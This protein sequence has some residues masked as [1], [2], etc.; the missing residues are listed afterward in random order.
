MIDVLMLYHTIGPLIM[1]ALRVLIVPGNCLWLKGWLA[2]AVVVVD[3][4]DVIIE[5]ESRRRRQRLWRL[6]ATI[7][8]NHLWRSKVC[9]VL[10]DRTGQD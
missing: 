2:A 4:V 5:G 3:V 8:H 7:T 6:E 1:T 10:H 9:V